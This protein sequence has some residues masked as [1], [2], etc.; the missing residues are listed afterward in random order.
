MRLIVS[1]SLCPYFHLAAEAFFLQQ[2]DENILLI[3]QSE[4][5][6]VSGKHQNIC[7]EINYKFCKENNILPARRLSGGG[8]VFHDMG[9]I[10]FTFIK[11]IETEMDKAVNYKQFLEPIRSALSSLGI[12]TTYS[13][14]DDLLLDG[15]K[16]SGNAQ[17]IFQQKKRVL[18]HGTLLYN[19]QLTN[20]SNALHSE[21]QYKDKAVKSVRSVVT[22]IKDYHNFGE[23]QDF[24]VKLINELS[25]SFGAAQF[26]SD[27]ETK[28]IDQIKKEKF[29]L[30]EWILGYSPKYIH[31]RLV[32]LNEKKYQLY[33]FVDKGE[34]LEM[35]LIDEQSEKCYISECLSCL[36]KPISVATF[37]KSFIEISETE[38]YQFL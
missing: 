34:V 27:N 5:A 6:V 28:R 7:A 2:T 4:S 8:T 33:M 23:T 1:R 21:G 12:E 9:N 26:I 25:T 38:I 29:E 37:K 18:H 24:L 11:N 17:H 36:S 35:Q 16:I 32:S 30:E 31:R 10:N 19:C 3:W 14:R 22:N 20:L 15:K 13:H